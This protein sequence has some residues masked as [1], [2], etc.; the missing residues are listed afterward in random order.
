[1]QNLNELPQISQRKGDNTPF[2]MFM[3]GDKQGALA[4]IEFDEDDMVEHFNFDYD[5]D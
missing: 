5:E 4:K 1:M 2:E 3:N